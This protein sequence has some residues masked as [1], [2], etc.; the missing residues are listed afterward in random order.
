M[1]TTGDMEN[2]L[3]TD[4]QPFGIALY[5]KDAVPEGEVKTERIVIIPKTLK[6]G[7]YW[8][9]A[10]VEVNFC[11]PDIKAGSTQMADKQRLR[12]IERQACV[13]ESVSEYDNTVYKYSVYETGQEKDAELKCHFVNVRLLFEILNTV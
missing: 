2:I 4:L 6:D 9:K 3:Y 8:K 13:L 11:V 10:F 1:I 5:K 12:A 7:V